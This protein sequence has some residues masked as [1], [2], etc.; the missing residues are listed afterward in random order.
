MLYGYMIWF[1][2]MTDNSSRV[3]GFL[4][5]FSAYPRLT[6]RDAWPTAKSSERVPGNQATATGRSIPH[7]WQNSS[8]N[9]PNLYLQSSASGTGF[10]S[11]GIP[12]GEC[13]TGVSVT[14]SSCALSLLSNQPWGTRNHASGL[15]VNDLLNAEGAP[16]A[17]LTASHGTTVNQYS[18]PNWSFKGNG[19]NGSSQE[20]CPALGL[21]QIS[22]PLNSQLSGELESSQQNRRQ[23]MELEHSRAYDTPTQHMHWS[24]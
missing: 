9:P 14:D 24:L 10:S 11:S 19:V 8:Q 21:G 13:F 7:P 6:G 23:Y 3:G 15:G 22:Q 5:D 1:F 20:M 16:V 12:A 17:Q 4:L 2:A 18:N